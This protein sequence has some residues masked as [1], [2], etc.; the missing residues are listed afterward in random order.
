MW[1]PQYTMQTVQSRF[2][3]S[4]NALCMVHGRIRARLSAALC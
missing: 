3:S 1:K 2:A 4:L